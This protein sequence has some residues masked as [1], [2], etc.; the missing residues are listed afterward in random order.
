MTIRGDGTTSEADRIRL[1]YERRAREI[2]PDYYSMA[3]GPVLFAYQQRVRAVIKNLHNFRM[4][5]L[6]DRKILEVGCGTGGWLADFEA[7]GANRRNLAGIE[8]NPSRSRLAQARFAPQRDERGHILTEG[9]DVRLG[10]ASNLPWPDAS[11]DIVLQG[12]VF[13]SILEDGMKRVVAGEM[14]RVL[15][16][17]GIVVWYDFFYD[18]PSNSNVRGIRSREIHSLFSGYDIQLKR[19]TLAPPIA[20]QIVPITWIGALLLEKI[21]IFNTHY[22]GII[23]K[24]AIS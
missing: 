19:I 15:K 21:S 8:L 18:N 24:Q 20:K 23:F 1:E 4:F 12:T 9:A 16:P 7:W 5:P 10:D 13:T 11:F 3:N 2:P 6:S 17:G 22:L 14:M